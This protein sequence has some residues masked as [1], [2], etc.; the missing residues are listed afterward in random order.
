PVVVISN[1]ER[2]V[3][4]LQAGPHGANLGAHLALYDARTLAVRENRPVIFHAAPQD[5]ALSPAGELFAREV[6]VDGAG[7]VTMVPPH[8]FAIAPPPHCI[9]PGLAAV[10]RDIAA[11][12][13]WHDDTSDAGVVVHARPTARLL[14]PIRD[15]RPTAL[16]VRDQ[17][18]VVA[19][20]RGRVFVVD[21]AR[22][23]LQSAI[24]LP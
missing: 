17:A 6:L 24:P 9:C 15:G 3:A 2:G 23:L 12:A 7:L 11:R 22:G 18:L 1:D 14:L 21:A 5:I 13:Y 16:S 10:A 8:A 20:D 19:D 4:A